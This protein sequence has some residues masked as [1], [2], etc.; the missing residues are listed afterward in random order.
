M[1]RRLPVLVATLLV[2]AT[3]PFS[4]CGKKP[5]AA[6]APA[7]GGGNPQKQP[8]EVT[9]ATRR[10]LVDTLTIVGSL[11]A[12]ESAEIRPEIAGL[13]REILFTEG[14]AVE[15]GAVLVRIDDAELR[16]QLAQVQ[17]R[18]HLA[19]LNVARSEN[20]SETNTIP[21]SETDRAR[22]E[23][24]SAKA[25]LALLQTRLEKTQVKAPFDGVVG[26]RVISPGDYVTASTVITSLDDLSRLKVDFQVPERFL[27]KVEIGTTFTLRSRAMASLDQVKGEVYFVSSVI[28]RNTRSSEVKGYLDKP[29]PALKPG[30]FA[31]IE[32]V[33]DVRR[34]ALTVPEGAIL[35]VPGGS[36]VIAVR[37]AGADKVA[38]FVQVQLG[39]RAKGL[40]EVTP[41]KGEL[42][43]GTPVVAAGVGA[44]IIF[45]NAKLEPRPIR[46]EFRVGN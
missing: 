22:S 21:Q 6:G 43:E 2:A 17:A 3:I 34:G 24:A 28:D 42:A 12:N 33:L 8:V 4:G 45:P 37:D 46:D 18:Y 31:N 1:Y 25:E 15:K 19:E 16:A 26:G 11:A 38:D 30:M 7:G 27:S 35:T 14:Q 13:V 10:D 23:F 29:P 5:S 44:L 9:S 40:V 39:M 36:Q 41:L 32:L 20:L